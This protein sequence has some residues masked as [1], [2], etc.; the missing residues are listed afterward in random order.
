MER[1]VRGGTAKSWVLSARA[2]TLLVLLAAV[3]CTSD[4]TLVDGGSKDSLSSN[5]ASMSRTDLGDD[6]P[7]TVD[8]GV[9]SCEGAGEVYFTAHGTRFAVNGLALGADTAPDIDAIWAKD[10]DIKGLKIDIG[11]IIDRG[12]AL[13]D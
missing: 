6:W 13:C 10:P 5:E 2:L 11:P 7:L 8:K 12:L 4:S 1:V 9:V 3:A